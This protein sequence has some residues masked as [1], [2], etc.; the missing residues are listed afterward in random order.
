L[1]RNYGNKFQK[2][3]LKKLLPGRLLFPGKFLIIGKTGPINQKTAKGE[4][5][6]NLFLTEAK[7]F[8]PRVQLKAALGAQRARGNFFGTR[9]P[10]FYNPLMARFPKLGT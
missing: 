8:P 4:I 7:N 6:G 2:H 1:A 9:I 5:G 10:V 3:W